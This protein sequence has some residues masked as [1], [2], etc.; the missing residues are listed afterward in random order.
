MILHT[1]LVTLPKVYTYMYVLSSR[2]IGVKI[3]LFTH[4]VWT[5]MLPKQCPISNHLDT[6]VNELLINKKWN[7]G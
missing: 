1:S 2:H 3:S 4:F 6:K 5:A 7:N